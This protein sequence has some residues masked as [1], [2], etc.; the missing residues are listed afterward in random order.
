MAVTTYT[1]LPNAAVQTG[2]VPRGSTITALRDNI[3][4]GLECDPTAP[5]NRSAWHPWNKLVGNDANNGVFY[6]FLVNGA[7][8]SVET[9]VFED[10]YEY[11]IRVLEMS[12]VSGSGTLQIELRRQSTGTYAG[13]AT[14]ITGSTQTDLHSGEILL[15]TVRRTQRNHFITGYMRVSP[16]ALSNSIVASTPINL[17][18]ELTAATLIDRARISFLGVNID[19]GGLILDRRRLYL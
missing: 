11:R 16:V 5:V 6:D 1:T 4:A 17:V 3:A 10:G 7:V 9:P 13:A 15:P 12:P 18:Q 2:G 8:A 14:L 19:A